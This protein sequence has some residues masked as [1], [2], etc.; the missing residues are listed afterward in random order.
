MKLNWTKKLTR[1][2]IKAGL[3]GSLAG[4]LILVF[5]YWLTGGR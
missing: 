4:V 3:L 1:A 5:F 2:E